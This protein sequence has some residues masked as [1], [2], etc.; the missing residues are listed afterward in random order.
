M[1]GIVLQANAFLTLKQD[2][3]VKKMGNK[4]LTLIQS[5]DIR[6]FD[7]YIND[8]FESGYLLHGNMC[9]VSNGEKIIY[10]QLLILNEVRDGK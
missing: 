5:D 3:K 8:A 4:P 1:T 6:K 10:V 9:V 2:S 7:E